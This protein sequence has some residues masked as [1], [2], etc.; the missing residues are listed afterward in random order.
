MTSTA[1]EQRAGAA[2][3]LSDFVVFDT[4]EIGPIDLEPHRLR[5]RIRLTVET[6]SEET[7]FIVRYEEP[8]FDPTDTACLNLA[9]MIA[10]QIALNYGLFCKSIVFNGLY[11][12]TDR[13]LI[14]E[15]A[16]NTAREIA[17]KKLFEP[18]A[19]LEPG[20]QLT[21]LDKP[22]R[23]CQATLSFPNHQRGKSPWAFVDTDKNRFLVLSSG[24]K[25]SLLS[26][27]LLKELNLETHPIFVNESGRHWFTALNAFRSFQKDV[28]HAARVW[29]NSDRVFAWMLRRMPFIRKDFSRIRSDEYPIR[30]WT[31]A[32]FL[33]GV[34]PLARKRRIG[35]IVVGN[36][37]D[38]TRRTVHQSVT[39]YDGLYDQSVFFDHALSRYYL[40]KGWGLSQFSLLRPCS[41]LLIQKTLM[42]RYP[43]L[44]RDQVSCHAAHKGDGRILPCGRCEKCRRIVAMITALGG[45][46]R[47]CGYDADQIR[48]CLADLTHHD[49]HQW[50]PDAQHLCAMLE[51]AGHVRFPAAQRKRVRFH[52]EVTCLRFDGERSPMNATPLDI[53]SR[54]LSLLAEH[55]D[56]IVHRVARRWQPID[57]NDHEGFREPYRFDIHT[58]QERK[59]GSDQLTHPPFQWGEL[60]WPDAASRLQAVD[61]ALLPV[62][63]IEQHGPHLPLDTDAFDAHYL[64]V[65]IAEASS[66][67]QPLV[68]PLI[69]YGVSFEHDGFPGTLSISNE[70]LTRMVTDVGISAARNGIRK[71]IIINGHGGNDA[72]LNFAAQMISRETKIFVCVDSGETSDVDISQLIQTPG[73]VHAGE[74]ETST[75]LAV[76]P[77]LV[78][79]DRVV[80]EVPTFSSRYLNLSSKRLVSWYA[81]T[82]RIS[83]SGVL[84][85]PTKATA[86]KGE[87]IWDIMIAH[88]VALVEDLKTVSLEE[89]Y[90]RRY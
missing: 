88:L 17:I 52:P 53:R 33:F 70:A 39:H 12:E 64:A 67:P 15:M 54:I 50:G 40:K 16:E 55:A 82:D 81:H 23:F 25:D 62:G 77:H 35:R 5:A 44:Q 10:A 34:L 90:Q 7:Q 72:A 22:T 48:R 61:L 83:R 60:T 45:D 8:V 19:F 89:L 28:P 63:S 32:I 21:H 14:R 46:P 87:K 47:H 4:L 84:G 85:D 27:G 24:G 11:D 71:L 69:P 73:D 43:H 79:L 65:R 74:I 1:F 13:Q 2:R 56:G 26:F 51:R 59:S 30:L 9:S 3:R 37:Y 6:R 66:H 18:N 76:R 31:V 38:T 80:E 42:V 78:R 57:L 68:M 29:I 58:A 86:D 75:A 20:T 36:E 41:E 49:V